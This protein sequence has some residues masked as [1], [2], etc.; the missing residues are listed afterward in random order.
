MGSDSD[1]PNEN[2]KPGSRGA[3]DSSSKQQD[4]ADQLTSVQHPITPPAN[5]DVNVGRLFEG[6]AKDGAWTTD[7]RSLT[8]SIGKDDSGTLN[9]L[10]KIVVMSWLLGSF[11]V[12]EREKERKKERERERKR[13]REKERERKREK[14]RERERKREREKERRYINFIDN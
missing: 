12:G 1:R 14:E 6:S 9:Y 4:S 7:L 2:F 3:A 10:M 8:S 5:V 13:E 11:K